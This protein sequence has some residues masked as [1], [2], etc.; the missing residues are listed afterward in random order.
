MCNA[1]AKSFKILGKRLNKHQGKQPK[2]ISGITTTICKCKECGLVFSNPI[3]IPDK[4]EDHY[5]VLPNDYWKSEY[6]EFDANYFRTVIDQLEQLM[7]FTLDRKA[8]DI[9]AG[10]GKSMIAL[11]NKGIDCY[12]LEPSKSFYDMAITKMGIEANKL[13]NKSIEDISYDDEIFDFI[14]FGAVLEHL[15]DPN[16]CLSKAM[17]WLKPKGLI[18]IEVPSSNWLINHLANLYYKLKNSDYVANISP[19]HS[20]YHLYEFSLESFLRNSALN[21]YFVEFHQYYVCQ[22]YMPKPFDKVLKN[23]MRATEKGMQLEVWLRK[24]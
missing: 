6:F 24:V 5:G 15:Y 23:Y 19:M 20:P 21:G 4:I 13:E 17:K 1:P 14:T 10:I 2:K 12:G 9:G 3:P 11:Q 8:L 22:T 16:F 7:P 18:H